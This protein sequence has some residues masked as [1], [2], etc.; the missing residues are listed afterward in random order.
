MRRMHDVALAVLLIGINLSTKGIVKIT[1]GIGIPLGLIHHG[2]ICCEVIS[3][4]KLTSGF[5]PVVILRI[6]ILRVLVTN[7]AKSHTFLKSLCLSQVLSLLGDKILDTLLI[8]VVLTDVL[9]S[10]FHVL[11]DHG[12][13]QGL[14]F[15]QDFLQILNL[16]LTLLDIEVL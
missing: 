4:G 2:V 5:C 13:R 10:L 8:T 1:I 14:I 16:G 9:Q 11:I 15:I 3:S 12:A 7:R 6:I